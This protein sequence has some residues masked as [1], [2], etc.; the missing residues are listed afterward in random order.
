VHEL[1]G[2]FARHPDLKL[3][4]HHCG[5]MVPYFEARLGGGLDQLGA[6]SEDEDDEGATVV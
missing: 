5:A 6:R 4:T 1:S 3:I 2:L